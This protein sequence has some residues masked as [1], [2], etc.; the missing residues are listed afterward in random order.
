[1]GLGPLL[2]AAPFVASAAGEFFRGSAA[3]EQNK[4]NLAAQAETNRR[5][6]EAKRRAESLARN[7]TGPFGS[8]SIVE[9]AEGRPSVVTDVPFGRQAQNVLG[10]QVE[11]NRQLS[12]LE[13]QI[14]RAQSQEPFTRAQAEEALR[15]DFGEKLP[16]IE[17]QVGDIATAL[18]RRYSP[19]SSNILPSLQDAITKSYSQLLPNINVEAERLSNE[20]TTARADALAAQRGALDPRTQ[21]Q[22]P[23][24][25]VPDDPFTGVSPQFPAGEAIA[26]VGRV[27]PSLTTAQ[28]IEGLSN[29]QRRIVADE[30][31]NA[32]IAALSRQLGDQPPVPTGPR[33]VIQSSGGK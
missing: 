6:D 31:T 27:V 16:Y 30:Q 5:A 17:G 12:E 18:R 2:A 8:S 11:T 20:I 22:A 7:F 26:D 4:A 29:V 13:Q 10:Q 32:L 9:D 23:Q 33:P 1:M 25:A 19:G 15:A 28:G 14:L 21:A 24:L 3:K